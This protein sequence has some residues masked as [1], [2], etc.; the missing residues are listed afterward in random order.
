MFKLRLIKINSLGYIVEVPLN[1][2]SNLLTVYK[3]CFENSKVD[4]LPP[5]PIPNNMIV[6]GLWLEF[7]SLEQRYGEVEDVR[8]V[9]QRAIQ[10]S[11]DNT[12]L[13][14]QRFLHFESV[15]G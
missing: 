10:C 12:E 11:T 3:L 2:A 6:T 9:F 1:K 5:L 13:I 4:V 15:Y 7:I 8:R 14:L